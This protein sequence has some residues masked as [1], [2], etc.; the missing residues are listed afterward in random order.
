MN[1]QFSMQTR[2]EFL[3]RSLAFGLAIPMITLA[4][5]SC[6]AQA[7]RDTPPRLVGGGCDGCEG[8][9]E[10]TPAKMDWQTTIAAASEPGERLEMSGVIYRPDGMTPA[11]EIILYVYHTDATGHYTPAPN[12]A[13]LTKRHGHLRGWMKT[14]A[15]GE[16]RFN[17]IRPAAY[18]TRD[19]PAHVHPVIKEPDKNEYYIDEFL[20]DDDPILTADKRARLE[21]RGGSGIVK[22]AKNPA[23]VWTG[24]RDIVL[25]LNIP[26]YA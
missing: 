4:D 17:T 6:D 25:G 23:G 16:Y 26:D 19:N 3:R 18:P 9:F 12:A 8:M 14:N 10:G 11:P 2:R 7:S 5:V 20:F 15:R 13:G 1:D 21:N 22:L 24:R